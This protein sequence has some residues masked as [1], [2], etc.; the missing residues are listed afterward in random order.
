MAMAVT[1]VRLPEKLDRDLNTLVKKGVYANKSDAVRDAVRRLTLQN[2][3]GII[4]NTGNSVKEVREI[5]KKLSKEKFEL[6]EL[7]KL[8]K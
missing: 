8:V 2:M 4:P 1:Q 5:R 7:N 3:I 6:D